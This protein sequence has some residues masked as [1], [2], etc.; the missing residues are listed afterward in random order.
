MK[1]CAVADQANHALALLS[2]MRG[3]EV[4]TVPVLRPGWPAE[5]RPD[6]FCFNVCI[7]ACAKAGMA[8]RALVLLSEMRSEG[9]LPDVVRCDKNHEF[10]HFQSRFPPPPLKI[11]IQ[12]L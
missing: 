5:V 10:L 11:D 9:V 8:N 6:A 4:G 7:S 2:S 3:K 1:A 12:W